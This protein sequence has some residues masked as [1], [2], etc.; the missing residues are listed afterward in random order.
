MQHC[1]PNIRLKCIYDSDKMKEKL[2]YKC[3]SETGRNLSGDSC[4][5]KYTN[6][7]QIL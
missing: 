2:Q 7:H 3:I 1:F 5:R 4:K 6:L